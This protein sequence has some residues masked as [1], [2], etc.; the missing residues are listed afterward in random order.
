MSLEYSPVF[1]EPLAVHGSY[2]SY[3]KVAV[4]STSDKI[5]Y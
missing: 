5:E 2:N 3:L 4:N 1:D